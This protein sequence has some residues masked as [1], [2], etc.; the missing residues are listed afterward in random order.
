MSVTLRMLF[1]VHGTCATTLLLLAGPV[2]L[3]EFGLQRIYVYVKLND[4]RQREVYIYIY[5]YT[6]VWVPDSSMMVTYSFRVHDG[7]TK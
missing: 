6:I 5:I 4:G 7:A 2:Q 1:S 3:Q